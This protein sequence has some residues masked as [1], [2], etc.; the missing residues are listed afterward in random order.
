MRYYLAYG[1]L[2]GA[3]RHKGYIPWDDD[4]DLIMPR[5]DYEKFCKRYNGNNESF[6]VLCPQNNKDCYINFAK[7]HDIRTRFQE[8]YSMLNNYGIFIDIF[9]FDGYIDRKQMK[10]CRFLFQLIHYKSLTWSSSN[11]FR[12]NAI[13]LIIRT[14]LFPFNMRKIL[15][16]LEKES[17]RKEYDSSEYV[18]FFSEKIPPIKREIFDEYIY[19]D[20]ENQK[21]RIPS[22]YDELLQLQYGDYMQLPPVEER[23]NKHQ[24]KAWWI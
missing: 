4:I 17:Q 12:K 19:T 15:E 20:F 16:R 9:P 8:S 6:K 5:P 14:I 3:I 10:K 2:I 13:L 22:K 23:I 18:Y 21:Y 1:T 24:A 11:S 7:V